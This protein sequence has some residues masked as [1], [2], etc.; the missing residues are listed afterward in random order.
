MLKPRQAQCLSKHMHRTN[1]YNNNDH[2]QYSQQRSN[3]RSGVIESWMRYNVQV[4][5]MAHLGH[6]DS[7]CVTQD[8]LKRLK[9][10]SS[11]CYTSFLLY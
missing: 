11:V 3:N 8:T 5:I 10:N 1:I 7:S 6:R 9:I 2:I 4:E